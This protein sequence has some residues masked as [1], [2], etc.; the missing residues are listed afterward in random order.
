MNQMKKNLEQAEL[1]LMKTRKHSYV[2][3]ANGKN[4][5]DAT[6]N[7]D[8]LIQVSRTTNTDLPKPQWKY[9]RVTKN[10]CQKLPKAKSDITF[11]NVP[12]MA[13]PLFSRFTENYEKSP[14]SPD[15]QWHKKFEIPLSMENSGS[16]INHCCAEHNN[17]ITKNDYYI[18][19]TQ[20]EYEISKEKCLNASQKNEMYR[21]SFQANCNQS[22]Q[23]KKDFIADWQFVE[24]SS[25]GM[26]SSQNFSLV[27]GLHYLFEKIIKKD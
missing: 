9:E 12:F 16:S 23:I 1:K 21:C 22:E 25:Q 11:E 24:R 27:N 8:A 3:G 4:T 13:N 18:K 17:P 5:V 2:T 19:G 6:E 20:I 10:D 7:T 14:H 26:F 15:C